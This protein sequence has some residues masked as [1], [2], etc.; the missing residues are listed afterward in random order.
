MLMACQHTQRMHGCGLCGGQTRGQIIFPI[1]IHQKADAAPVHAINR[2]AAAQEAMQGFQHEAIA[3]KG[4]DH[5]RIFFCRAA[6]TRH[7]RGAGLLCLG[8]LPG[9]DGNAAG[10]EGVHARG[11]PAAAARCSSKGMSRRTRAV[12]A[13]SIRAVAWPLPSLAFATTWPQ[14]SA[15]SEWP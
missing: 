1:I 2:Q 12:S 8:A 9:Q 11:Q 13:W 7:Q 3:A 6:I 5:F 4:D 15:I 10:R 14:G